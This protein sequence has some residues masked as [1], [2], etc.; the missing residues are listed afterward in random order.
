MTLTA[1]IVLEAGRP[2][3][4]I[5]SHATHGEPLCVYDAPVDLAS[6]TSIK[7][8]IDFAHE[9]SGMSRADLYDVFRVGR[10]EHHRAA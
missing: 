5:T 10:R 7:A 9:R 6:K 4:Y 8:E 1:Q 2:W 3:L